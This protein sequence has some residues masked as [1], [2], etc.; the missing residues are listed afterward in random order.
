[1]NHLYWVRHGE[2]LA[3]LTKQFSS[4]QVDFPLT[5]KGILQAR[6]TADYLVEKDI[7]AIFS[8]PLKRAK[9]TA[10]VIGE[11]LGLPVTVM[12]A[13]REVDTGEFEL[14]KPTRAL[15]DRHDQIL[16]GWISGDLETGFP[17]GETGSQL[18]QRVLSGLDQ[19]ISGKDGQNLVV[20]GHGGNLSVTLP[21][22]C[23]SLTG[24]WRKGRWL[25][26]CSITQIDIEKRDGQLV[27]DLIHWADH[28][29]LYGEA[30]ELVSGIPGP[31]ELE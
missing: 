24:D 17:G 27:G 21:V 2:N 6:Q 15:W 4:R 20:V 22:L 28:G 29:H 18:R 10:D 16:L 19:V 26:N 25:S 1:M 31:G 8:S 12:E 30:A 23:P 9:E 7:Q 3:N 11:K 13:F 14:H 5:S